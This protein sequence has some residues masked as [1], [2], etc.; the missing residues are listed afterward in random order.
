MWRRRDGGYHVRARVKD[1]RTGQMKE[2]NR[3]LADVAKARDAFAWLQTE[4]ERARAGT[5]EAGATAPPFHTFAA[6]VFERKLALGKIRSASGRAKWEAILKHH[7]VPAFGEIFMDQLRPQDVKAWQARMAGK[8]KARD[9]APATAN[10]II[11]VL[12]QITDEAI[13]D[14]DIRDPMRGVDLFDM[15]EHSTYTE[16]EP[17]SLAPDDVPRFLATLRDMHPEHYAFSFL[18][19]T[20]GL[21][22]S[23]LRP[24]RRAGAHADIKWKEGILLIRRSQTL[25]DDVMETTKT[26]L[27]QR[28]TLPPELLDVLHWHV[29]EMLTLTKMRSSE[30]LFPAITGGFRSRSCLDKPFADVATAIKLPHRFTPRGMRR[31]YQDLARAAGVHDAVTR[32]ISGHATP[33]MQ[34]HYSTAR[35]DEVRSALAQVAGI[36][37]GAKV[38]DL[39]TARRASGA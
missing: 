34:L 10:T 13:T 5:P 1:P 16:E 35:G 14:F 38:I 29:D 39:A 22:P 6:D 15:R 7:L 30:L 26:D 24:L 28:L 21:R 31:T 32:A 25:G 8:I 12:R 23:S 11:S 9:M 4:L 20:T 2:I 36:A 18:G 3:A 33:A 17:N 19:F 27:H 37:T